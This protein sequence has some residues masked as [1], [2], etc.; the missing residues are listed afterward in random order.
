MNTNPYSADIELDFTQ[1][2]VLNILNYAEVYIVKL[3]N[4]YTRKIL[5]VNHLRFT[6]YTFVCFLF[7]Q[8]K[9]L[10]LYATHGCLVV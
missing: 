9:I 4:A 1:S 3:H 2:H 6:F 5:F 8:L 10:L 7:F